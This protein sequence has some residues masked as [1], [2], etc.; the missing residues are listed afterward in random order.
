MKK[1]TTR[2]HRIAIANGWLSPML[3]LSKTNI[4]PIGAKTSEQFKTTTKKDPSC[5]LR[6]Q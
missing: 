4:A 5:N 1:P 3:K 6:R 2:T